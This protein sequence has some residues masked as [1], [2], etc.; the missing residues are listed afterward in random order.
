MP[1]P[2]RETLMDEGYMDMSLVMAALGEVGFD[3][4][5]IPDHIPL[6]T[7]EGGDRAGLGY[8]IG[9]MR[10]LNA[11]GQHAGTACV[12]RTAMIDLRLRHCP[13]RPEP[14]RCA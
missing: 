8:S 1:E 14:R 11:G 2:W 13:A 7:G 9:Y 4:C 12:F 10:A 6:M 3:G 5:A